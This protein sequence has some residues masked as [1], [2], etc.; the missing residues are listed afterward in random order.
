MKI[1]LAKPADFA[2]ILELQAQ[3][4]LSATPENQLSDGFVTTQL[5]EETLEKRREQRAIWVARIG[6]DLVAYACAV[7]WEFYANSR[8]VEMVF[9][10][11]PLPFGDQTVTADNSFIYGPACIASAARGQGILPQIVDAVKARY[12][13]N[14]A[15]GVCF[16]DERNA[17]SLA[18]HER[19]L[20][21]T[22]IAT[23]PFGDV[24]YHMLAFETR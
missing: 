2:E 19:K 15:F 24:I 10:H 12:A 13:E 5:D 6:D 20:G 7:E 17:R 21:F 9:T 11:F 3:F 1:Q 18:A 16:I 23:K 22:R 14:R 8:F 4:H